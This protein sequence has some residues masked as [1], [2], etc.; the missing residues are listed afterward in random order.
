[1]VKYLGNAGCGPKL[2]LQPRLLLDVGLQCFDDLDEILLEALGGVEVHPDAAPRHLYAQRQDGGLQFKN[3]PQIFLSQFCLEDLP[4]IERKLGVGLGIFTHKA[5]GQL[6][7]FALGVYAKLLCGLPERGLGLHQ[8]QIIVADRVER[9]AEAVFV[10]QGRGQHGVEHLAF[11]VN[12]KALEPANVV[13]RVEENLVRRVVGYLFLEPAHDNATVQI[14]A[15]LM[16]NGQ[17]C[18]KPC[19]CD[20]KPDHI[21]VAGGPS[22]TVGLEPWVFSLQVDGDFCDA[23]GRRG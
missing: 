15:A 10:K 6:V 7:E 18:V 9:V 16:G 12:A 3:L 4:Q 19:V 1:M 17:V 5:G 22:R 8:P 2:K 23:A 14:A 11:Q 21:A 20:G 13:G